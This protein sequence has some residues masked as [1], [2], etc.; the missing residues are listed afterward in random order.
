MVKEF[1]NYL[2][3]FG[4]MSE[5]ELESNYDHDFIISHNG[6]T[7]NIPFDAN[8]HGLIYELINYVLEEL[9]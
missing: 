5:E 2:K 1:Q 9:T 3:S 8:T 4:N 6:H 7:V